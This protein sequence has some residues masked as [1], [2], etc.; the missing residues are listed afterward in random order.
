MRLSRGVFFSRSRIKQEAGIDS[1]VLTLQYQHY[2][3]K[4]DLQRIVRYNNQFV[5]SHVN[6]ITNL[7]FTDITQD[8][9][10]NAK[11]FDFEKTY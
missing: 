3:D 8:L 9:N 4:S 7:C 2:S 11:M 10:K 6:N 1:Y 5:E